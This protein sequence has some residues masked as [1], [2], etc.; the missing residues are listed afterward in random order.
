MPIETSQ[1]I[2]HL[3]SKQNAE[4]ED[5]LAR[6]WQIGRNSH[7][8]Q[9]ILDQLHPWGA[10][11]RLKF[12][13]ALAFV[14][15]G[16]GTLLLLLL[17]FQPYALLSQSIAFVGG[18]LIFLSY[19]LYAPQRP[20]D[21]VIVYLQDSII[22]KRYQL[23]YHK[24]PEALGRPLRPTLLISQLKQQ[25]PIFNRGRVSNEIPFF[26]SCVWQEDNGQSHQVLIFEYHFVNQFASPD[27]NTKHIR[28]KEIH[29]S[30][31]GVFVFN[32]EHDFATFAASTEHKKLPYPYHLQWHSSDIQIR[33]RLYIGGEN[34]LE[35]AK[36]MTPAL[37]LK[38]AEFFRQREG[39]LY[40][41]PN[42]NML[43]YL[44]KDPLMQIQRQHHKK[45]Q[46]ISALRGHLRTFKLP[47][48]ERLKNDL[49]CLLQ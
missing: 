45:I 17:L 2:L 33:Q 24:V 48:L 42:Q 22:A 16:M 40:I 12:D 31:W 27:P 3:R 15:G 46:D 1:R 43:C 14:L 37:T 21:E 7:S 8:A 32:L 28:P 26:A 47:L 29:Q 34:P 11:R 10:S 25:F 23:N 20:I 44:G 5:N 6:L 38:L 30:L 18:C 13:N 9:D 35:L 19:L 39:E 36:K 49:L 41:N 4:V